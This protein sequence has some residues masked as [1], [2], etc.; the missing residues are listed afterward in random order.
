MAENDKG[1]NEKQCTVKLSGS[2]GIVRKYEGKK[3][4]VTTNLL[5]SLHTQL[6]NSLPFS[7]SH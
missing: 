2:D 3:S 1:L 4:E 7:S 5:F 6:T